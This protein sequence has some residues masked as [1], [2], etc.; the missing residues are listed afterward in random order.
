MPDGAFRRPSR[1]PSQEGRSRSRPALLNSPGEGGAVAEGVEE[2]V[3]VVEDGAPGD[4]R[5][6]A[7]REKEIRT[8]VGEI[9]AG[10]LAK[11]DGWVF[12]KV[13]TP[14]IRFSH[15]RQ[16]WQKGTLTTRLAARLPGNPGESTVRS[17]LSSLQYGAEA[18]R[19]LHEKKTK[20][21]G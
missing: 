4:H 3:L 19:R 1:A 9:L 21:H 7:A 14:E 6:C 17:G 10:E 5:T 8:L 11:S 2:V 20:R 18:S 12:K 15:P 13:R 16:F